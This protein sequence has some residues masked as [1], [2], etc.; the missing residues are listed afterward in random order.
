MPPRT[1]YTQVTMEKA[2][3]DV[4]SK[5]HTASTA[6]QAYGIPSRTLRKHL[7]KAHPGVIEIPTS[8]GR[9]PI[10]PRQYEE[11]LATWIVG[12]ERDGKP[13]G[14]REIVQK[15]NNILDVV[16]DTTNGTNL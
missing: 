12:M 11:D 13:V 5:V 15:A 3:H 8:F 7:A 2:V 14:Y 9:A 16:H 6:A 1:P 10:L 4:L